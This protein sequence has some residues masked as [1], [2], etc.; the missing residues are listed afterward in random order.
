MINPRVRAAEVALIV[1]L[2]L[3][4]ILPKP[5]RASTFT[6]NTLDDHNDG[7]CT[8]TDCTLR[9]ALEAAQPPGTCDWGI[10]HIIDF[11]V[12]GTIVLDPAL[13]PLPDLRCPLVIDG[14][15]SVTI[16]GGGVVDHAL[17]A[18]AWDDST[19][20]TDEVIR[21]LTFRDFAS[22]ALGAF[23][24]G[25]PSGSLLVEDS[26]FL[27]SPVGI[28]VEPHVS[29]SLTTLR[30]V[31]VDGAS[32]WGVV[33][34]ATAG[35]VL[36][37]SS[38]VTNCGT[39][40]GGGI[41]VL[42]SGSGTVTLSHL[43][44]SG[45][46]IGIQVYASPSYS[47][48][49]VTEI[50]YSEIHDNSRQGVLL[51]GDGQPVSQ[52]YVGVDSSL[53][54]RH[55][56]IFNN[57]RQG[58]L[59]YGQASD[60]WVWVN[61]IAGNAQEGL[62]VEA[63]GG[64]IRDVDVRYNFIYDNRGA[65]VVLTGDVTS[66]LIKGNRIGINGAM[67]PH[68]NG[69]GPGPQSDG[70]VVLI[71]GPSNNVVEYNTV[72][73]SHYHNILI[74][75]SSSN[76]I[77][78]NRIWGDHALI[79]D[80]Y[81]GIVV[82]DGSTSN[83]MSDNTISRHV[84]EGIVIMGDGTDGN[85]V[86][87]NKIGAYDVSGVY[88][89]DPDDGNGAGIAVISAS[90]PT[91]ITFPFPVYAVTPAGMQPGP[92]RTIVIGNE[93]RGN[94]GD[95]IILIRTGG[96]N[97]EANLVQENARYGI[98]MIASHPT[99][100]TRNQL[101]DNGGDGMRVEPFYGD[102]ASP[103]DP[104]DDVLSS[105]P[106]HFQDNTIRGNAGYGLRILDN[107]WEP[108]SYSI[109]S[110]TISGNSAGDAVKEWLGYVKVQ[111]AHGDP[112]TG[113]TVRIYRGGDDGDSVPD[114]VSGA[115]DADGRYGPA[116]FVYTDVSTWWRIVQEE[117]RGSTVYEY[118]PHTFGTPAGRLLGA[119][120]WDGIYPAPPTESGGAF[121]SPPLSGVWRYQWA[122]ATYRAEEAGEG[123]T[124]TERQ[125]R[126]LLSLSTS[127]R[128]VSP[129]DG[130]TYRLSAENYCDRE[131][132]VKVRIPIPS[133]IEPGEVTATSGS[134][135]VDRA[136][137]ELSWDL[138]LGGYSNETLEMNSTVSQE[139]PL[140]T[141]ISAKAE[142]ECDPG[143]YLSAGG[144]DDPLTVGTFG[145]PTSRVVG[146]V[147]REVLPSRPVAVPLDLEGLG[148]AKVRFSGCDG[149]NL[150]IR[151]MSDGWVSGRSEVKASA[152]A[153][154][155]E[156]DSCTI[157][158]IPS[159]VPRFMSAA[160]LR[161]LAIR[162]RVMGYPNVTATLRPES[163]AVVEGGILAVR[164]VVENAGTARV[165]YTLTM[166][167]G[168]LAFHTATTSPGELVS[169]NGT[170]VWV[171]SSPP[172]SRRYLRVLLSVPKGVRSAEISGRLTYTWSGGNGSLELGGA[173]IKVLPGSG[174]GGEENES[175][176]SPSAAVSHLVTSSTSTSVP[177]GIN[178][179]RAAVI[180]QEEGK[181]IEGGGSAMNRGHVTPSEEP[182]GSTAAGGSVLEGGKSPLWD[183]EQLRLIVL[184]S[185]AAMLL[186]LFLP[187]DS[188]KSPRRR[189]R[190]GEG[191]WR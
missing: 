185:L 18:Y 151:G 114:Y 11:S 69:D 110:N 120:W 112:V 94:N 188:G 96:D 150:S 190:S 102:L 47:G 191:S 125:C 22:Y 105:V 79:P 1:I 90:A 89:G 63:A 147:E 159:K 184:V 93:V 12:S 186:Y 162:L 183:L 46:G 83:A 119:Y 61:D 115:W 97:V 30:Q 176:G 74:S 85:S 88:T 158:L 34:R 35:R 100:V 168:G 103:L 146:E 133:M 152:P 78:Y 53:N 17:N 116:G 37:D 55:N 6:V 127:H 72:A 50:I 48:S 80:G 15:G 19:F 108:L 101:L 118:N 66:S 31:T 145:D 38:T 164:A 137:G 21:G 82:S 4:T 165:N 60:I 129:G 52:V 8:S 126:V 49:S 9:E 5:V 148:D 178:V 173:K 167:L 23:I 40:S 128:W 172:H 138:T 10:Q 140:G 109:S 189:V 29:G 123:G 54:Y 84:A 131:V 64:S 76:E 142:A 16:S 68:P 95:G 141:V 87:N 45:N 14:G 122:L 154:A 134:A 62:K 155:V 124:V 117:A 20:S 59:V 36:V 111:D 67:A 2:L 86:I 179:S 170:L 32:Q 44:V 132:R 169:T 71:D 187:R 42:R 51:N 75:A 39:A 99:Y 135:S 139:A 91:D 65:G 107:D 175:A 57:G 163:D 106:T 144:S 41:N 181:E 81:H 177:P 104:N 180:Q 58:V 24:W 166:S 26:T 160:G 136:G 92:E 3:M 113:L 28:V 56:D 77:R 25:T 73:Y 153:D 7:V 98:Y 70:G 161:S 156:G 171:Y 174:A 27:S 121:R 149:W 43:T 182:G 130:L 33:I 143:C 13:G 157:V